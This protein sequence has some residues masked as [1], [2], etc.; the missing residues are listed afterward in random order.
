MKKLF[1][2][3]LALLAVGFASAQNEIIDKFNQGATAY[4]AKDFATA[5]ACFEDVIK[6]GATTEDAN[7]LPS[8]ENAKKFLPA[9]YYSMGVMSAQQKA[10]DKAE[11]H[12]NKAISVAELYHN[13]GVKQ[14]ANNVLAKVYLAQGTD[15]FN[16]KDYATAAVAFEKAYAANPRNLD[17]AN[18]LA[19]C[20][21]EVGKFA[22][23]FAIYD[24]I[25]TLPA[26]KY[27]A[28]I[29]KAKA[30]KELYTTNMVAKMQQT[31]DY[32][33]LIKMADE[34]VEKDPAL[35]ERLR[36]DAYYNKRDYAK[37]IS[38]VDSAVAAQTTEEG[39]SQIYFILAA[40]YNA[41]YK[42]SGFK[43]TVIRDKA[44]EALKKVTAGKNVAAAKA[45]LADLTKK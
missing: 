15:P 18:N 44:I 2:T 43:N 42:A 11:E 5:I 14:K 39:R 6:Q 38:L 7:V 34:F 1:V 28:Q 16:A 33:G 41:Q 24:K 13:T 8:V 40:T 29:E 12:L 4:N 26:E 31:K 45:S 23:G 3:M 20:Y 10:F 17:V 21:C 9:C 37:V 25:C 22:E 27:A 36:I 30:N 32:D 35:A 19:T